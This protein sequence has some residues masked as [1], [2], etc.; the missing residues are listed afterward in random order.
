MPSWEQILQVMRD[1]RLRCYRIDVE[2][3]ETAFGDQAAEQQAVTELLQG[4]T[5]FLT[6]MAPLVQTGVVTPEIAKSMLMLAVRRFKAGREIEDALEELGDNPIPPPPDPNAGKMEVERERLGFEREKHQQEMAFRQQEHDQKMA[7]ESD[8]MAFERESKAVDHEF[9]KAQHADDMAMRE[10]ERAD[11]QMNAAEER[12]SREK[13]A[14]AKSKP[15]AQI[16][17]DKDGKTADL[18]EGTAGVAAAVQQMTETLGQLLQMNA[19]AE[20]R[21][22]VA[23]QSMGQQI[24]QALIAALNTPKEVKRGK[25]G[26]IKA[27]VPVMSAGNG[28]ARM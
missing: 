14:E 11:A 25:D 3:D 2:T 18:A 6:G 9:A 12:T 7:Q 1:D 8:R 15:A 20:Q 10:R 13:I 22:A 16:M 28:E 17:F 24:G 5:A 4:V 19:A 27:V 23:I 21:Q 26:K